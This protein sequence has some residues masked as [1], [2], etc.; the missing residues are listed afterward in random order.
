[1]AV[2]TDADS[3][4]SPPKISALVIAAFGARQVG[5]GLGWQRRRGGKQDR[6]TGVC[7]VGAA[8]QCVG[9]RDATCEADV[10]GCGEDRRGHHGGGG[11]PVDAIQRNRR[12]IGRYGWAADCVDGARVCGQVGLD[13][14]RQSRAVGQQDHAVLLSRCRP[15][16]QR[17]GEVDSGREEHRAR[18]TERRG[19]LQRRVVAI[20][21]GVA[22]DLESEAVKLVAMLSGIA[23]VPPS[24]YTV[25]PAG[26]TRTIPAR[27]SRRQRAEP[28]TN[29]SGAFFA[30][31]SAVPTSASG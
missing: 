11:V 26:S 28:C 15:G 14:R 25:P 18:A 7:L 12:V 17:V 4:A 27:V 31:A 3:A 22:N 9:E 24:K 13:R 29:N 19:H 5:G 30:A 21:A 1:M 20:G 6:P 23:A 10:C 2:C 8:A 16:T